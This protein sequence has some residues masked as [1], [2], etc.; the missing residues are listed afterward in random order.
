MLEACIRNAELEI[1]LLDSKD[2]KNQKKIQKLLK[3][4]ANAKKHIKL[5]ETA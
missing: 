5:L 4:I 2:I 1:T 3:G